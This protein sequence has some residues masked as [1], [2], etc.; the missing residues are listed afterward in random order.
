M[1]STDDGEVRVD[2]DFR[3]ARQVTLPRGPE[4]AWLYERVHAALDRCNEACF[5]FD[6]RSVEDPV[7]VVD[8]REG[9]FFEWHYDLAEHRRTRKLVASVM[10]S[11]PGDYEGGALALPGAEFPAIPRG[12]AVVFPSFLLHGV[13]PVKGGC[14]RVLVAIATGPRFR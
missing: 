6:L 3:R 11:D 13:R 9:D 2:R 4:T 8:Y 1:V 5:G 10:L 14:R 12:G 7:H